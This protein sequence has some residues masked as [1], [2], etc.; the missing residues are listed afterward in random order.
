M[1]MPKNRFKAAL[2]NIEAAI[3]AVGADAGILARGAEALAAKFRQ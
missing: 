3:C 1:E 2:D